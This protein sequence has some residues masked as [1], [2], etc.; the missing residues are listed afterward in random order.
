MAQS[1]KRRTRGTARTTA[2]KLFGTTGEKTMET[3]E[4][5]EHM[6]L[7]LA[8][9]SDERMRRLAS[10]AM[11]PEL[12]GSSFAKLAERLGLNFHMIS[13]EYRAIKKSE[14]YIA[15]ARHLPEIME[16]VAEEAKSRVEVCETCDGLGNVPD[17]KAFDELCAVADARQTA[18]PTE[19]PRMKCKNCKGAGEIFIQ[20]DVDRLKLVFDTFG[21]TGKGGGVNVNLDLRR[22]P[23]PHESM[24]DLSA[25]I[26]PILEGNKQ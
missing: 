21:L 25:S 20:G 8:R 18:R 7:V 24:A 3:S 9:S 10:E 17:I 13:E 16:Q 6:A 14:G 5:R 1:S 12:K 4:Q 2:R 19:A 22:P 26:A 15:A 11:L 23:D